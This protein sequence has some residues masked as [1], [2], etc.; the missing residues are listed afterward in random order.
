[1][2]GY[3]GLGLEMTRAY[4]WKGSRALITVDKMQ[5]CERVLVLKHSGAP[6]FVRLYFA[7]LL[8][9]CFSQS[10]GSLLENPKR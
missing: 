3:L 10:E 4:G 7:G 6:G 1:M 8:E 5:G 9:S 2:P